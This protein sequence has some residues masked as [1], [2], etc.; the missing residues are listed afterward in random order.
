[1]TTVMERTSAAE[2][3]KIRPLSK[4]AGAEIVGLDLRDRSKP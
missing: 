2:G 4:V 1:M 3:Y